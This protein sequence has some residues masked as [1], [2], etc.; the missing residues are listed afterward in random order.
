[1][2]RSDPGFFEAHFDIEKER[3][4][5]QLQHAMQSGVAYS[6]HQQPN[7]QTH[8]KHLRVGVNTAMVQIA[9]LVN[10]LVAAG[11]IDGRKFQ[12]EANRLMRREVESYEAELREAYGTQ[13]KLA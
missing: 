1:M 11:V 5:Q 8:P 7:D 9:A 2:N 12:D 6:M 4:F 13:I 3:L 10:T